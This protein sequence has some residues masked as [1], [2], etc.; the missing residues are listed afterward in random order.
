MAQG[1]GGPDDS[2]GFPSESSGFESE[3]FGVAAGA[4]ADWPPSTPPADWPP[5][6]PPGGLQFWLPAAGGGG[7]LRGAYIHAF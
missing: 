6:P 5:S 4:A 1:I 3:S 2:C 7:K